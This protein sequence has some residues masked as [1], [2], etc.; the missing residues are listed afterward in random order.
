MEQN[1]V[2]FGYTPNNN[3]WTE[4]SNKE[5]MQNKKKIELGAHC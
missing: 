1:N 2:S 3:K 4:T 5:K